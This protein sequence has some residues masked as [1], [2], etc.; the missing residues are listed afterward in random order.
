M[1]EKA[2]R[3]YGTGRR[4]ESTARVWITAGDGKFTINDREVD[5]YFPREALRFQLQQP[6]ETVEQRGKI[7]VIVNVAGGG[8]AGQA[9]AVRHGLARALIA[10]NNELR[11]PLKKAGLLTR[12]PRAV[13][14]KKY[15]R[16]GAR[17]RFQFSKR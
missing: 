10:M 1:R 12:D 13:E 17:K 3:W 5:S 8:V 16:P 14:R 15:G 2:E 9:G 6:L 7:D 4:K 11:P